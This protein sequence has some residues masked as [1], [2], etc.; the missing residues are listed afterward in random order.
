[1][2]VKAKDKLLQLHIF[3]IRRRK[4]TSRKT[5]AVLL[6]MVA[7]IS[8]ISTYLVINFINRPPPPLTVTFIGS[9]PAPPGL[10]RIGETDIEYEFNVTVTVPT[11]MNFPLGEKATPSAISHALMPLLGKYNL[12]ALNRTYDG[13]TI[14]TAAW[15]DEPI[16]EGKSIFSLYSNE[17][18]TAAT[19]ESLTNDLFNALTD[20]MNA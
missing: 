9:K 18:F 19:V 4:R 16:V 10:I 7:V 11:S 17:T 3:S 8:I 20:A 2:T 12:L 1:M 5:A 6:I 15:S 13:S 14:T